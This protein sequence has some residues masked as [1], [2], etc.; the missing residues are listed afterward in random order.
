MSDADHT[1]TQAVELVWAT[2]G[3]EQR[4]LPLEEALRDGWTLSEMVWCVRGSTYQAFPGNVC[5]VGWDDAERR[6][7]VCCR[8]KGTSTII[9]RFN[10]ATCGSNEIEVNCPSKKP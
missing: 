9:S 7:C 4:A 10:G 1:S 5:P 8:V 2:K 3:D 6:P